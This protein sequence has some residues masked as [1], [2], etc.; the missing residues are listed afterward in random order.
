MLKKTE[1]IDIEDDEILAIQK[2]LNNRPRK[3]SNDRT[4]NE[5]M[6]KIEKSLGVALHG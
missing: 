2:A 3:V 6:R 1:F 5:M 4:P